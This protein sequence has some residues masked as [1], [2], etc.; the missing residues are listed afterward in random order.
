MAKSVSAINCGVAVLQAWNAL[1]GVPK[2]VGLLP[3]G[4][5]SCRGV[6]DL[7]EPEAEQQTAR[8]ACDAGIYCAGY[9]KLEE[10]R[11]RRQMLSFLPSSPKRVMIVFSLSTRV[12]AIS[13]RISSFCGK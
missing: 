12:L 1:D 13:R 5:P 7:L 6:G 11:L 2:Y 4:P 8:A 10:C 9:F 3:A